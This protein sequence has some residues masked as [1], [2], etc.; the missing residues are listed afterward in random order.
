M[1]LSYQETVV[2]ICGLV[3]LL[4]LN[5]SIGYLTA[6]SKLIV[7][8]VFAVLWLLFLCYTSAKNNRS[9]PRF[10]SKY[11]YLFFVVI[12]FSGYVYLMVG[13][14]TED[15]LSL[16]LNRLVATYLLLSPFLIFKGSYV[17]RK[18]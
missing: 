11:E 13:V 2:F 17:E 9:L 18:S 14:K 3:I 10:F 12:A 8:L 15:N 16:F 7:L 6:W 1:K 4:I 5:I